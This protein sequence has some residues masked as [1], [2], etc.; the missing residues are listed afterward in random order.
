MVDCLRAVI[1][2]NRGRPNSGEELP[3]AQ[4][5]AVPAERADAAAAP[6][7][8]RGAAAAATRDLVDAVLGRTERDEREKAATVTAAPP[9][10]LAEAPSTAI[11]ASER[12][13]ERG[14]R[15]ERKRQR[16]VQEEGTNR[17]TGR[18]PKARRKRRVRILTSTLSSDTP[19]ERKI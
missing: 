12:A 5:G 4:Y 18:E 13:A 10:R 1:P 11:M 2:D 8:P 17:R 19:K 9:R 3:R 7:G 16:S 6:G 15:C 14:L